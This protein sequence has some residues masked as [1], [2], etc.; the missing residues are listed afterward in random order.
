MENGTSP[1][2][3]SLLQSTK[4]KRVRDMRSAFTSEMEIKRLEV[5]QLVFGTALVQNFIT[6]TFWNGIVYHVIL[7]SFHLLHGFYFIGNCG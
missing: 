3:T 7:K 5:A 2:E 4:M 6:M 1:G